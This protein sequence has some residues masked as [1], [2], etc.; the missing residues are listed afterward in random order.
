[1]GGRK[2]S[3]P[4]EVASEW[5][6]V[7]LAMRVDQ[8]ISL[9]KAC[10]TIARD[11]PY[12][13][14]TVYRYVNLEARERANRS[15]RECHHREAERKRRRKAYCLHYSR[16]QRNARPYVQALFQSETQRDLASLADD[17]T[18]LCGGIRYSR[19][20][21]QGF[22]RGYRIAQREGRIRGPPYLDETRPGVWRYS[23]ESIGTQKQPRSI[24]A[25]SSMPS[26]FHST[27]SSVG[28]FVP[29]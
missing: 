2:P 6:R 19:R 4:E 10:A 3:V 11:V 13:D 16:L 24:L 12:S 21:V 27:S 17:L 14:N 29:C 7:A 8:G 5:R 23:D 20:T 18:D 28:R 22:L 26:S 15:S 9:W 25:T 1:M